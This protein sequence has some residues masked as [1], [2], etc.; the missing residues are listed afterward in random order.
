M[1]RERAFQVLRLTMLSVD[2]RRDDDDRS[3]AI[4]VRRE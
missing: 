4:L 1:N 3:V 2:D